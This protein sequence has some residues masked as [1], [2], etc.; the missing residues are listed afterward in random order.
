M[1]TTLAS[2]PNRHLRPHLPSCTTCSDPPHSVPGA[3]KMST[4]DVG[5]WRCSAPRPTREHCANF[6]SS[7]E[8]SPPHANMGISTRSA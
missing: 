7:F 6:P 8:A 3:A 2:R 1:D 5:V 4:F